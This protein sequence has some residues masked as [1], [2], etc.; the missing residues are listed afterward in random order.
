MNIKQLQYYLSDYWNLNY[1]KINHNKTQEG[2]EYEI[3]KNKDN[4]LYKKPLN[5]KDTIY[6]LEKYLFS[7]NKND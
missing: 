5:L 1:K 4:N 6:V 2:G 7:S 3:N